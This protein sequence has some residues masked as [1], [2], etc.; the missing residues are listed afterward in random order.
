[1][2]WKPIEKGR[3]WSTASKAPKRS[4]RVKTE[5]KAITFMIKRSFKAQKFQL[6]MKTEVI[7]Q[8]IK[9][10]GEALISIDR[11]F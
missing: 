2:S 6:S 5:K 11:L 3:G 7:L 8:R 9:K 1:M 10:E 4:R